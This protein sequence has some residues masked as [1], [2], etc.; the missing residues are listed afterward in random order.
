[1]QD[2]ENFVHES[3]W[4]LRVIHQAS[5]GGFFLS[6]ARHFRGFSFSRATWMISSFQVGLQ[7]EDIR[8]E[9]HWK[10]NR[11]F[12]EAIVQVP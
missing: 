3:F 6:C 11:L 9:F 8:V 5:F 4:R 2:I 10:R 1:M 12:D 7:V